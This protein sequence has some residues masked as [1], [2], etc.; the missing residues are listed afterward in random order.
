MEYLK[1]SLNSIPL[2][3]SYEGDNDLEFVSY[4]DKSEEGIVFFRENHFNA[5]WDRKINNYSALYL[6]NNQ[7]FDEFLT[8]KNIKFNTNEEYFTTS[9]IDNNS[10]LYLTMSSINNEMFYAFTEKDQKFIDQND[11]I[12]ELTIL[13]GVSATISH[14]HR[15]K[16]FYYLNFNTDNTFKFEKE[17]NNN[18]FN[19]IVDRKNSKMSLFKKL[20]LLTNT[21]I[22]SNL[23]LTTINSLTAFKENVFNINYYLETLTPKLNTSWASYN[24]KNINLYD[25]NNQRS[26]LNLKNNYLITSQYSYIS[27]NDLKCNILTLKNQKT[28]KH[29][30]HRSNYLEKNNINYPSVNHRNYI[31]LFSGSEQELGDHTIT[32]SYEFYNADYKFECDKYTIFI[33]PETLYPYEQININDLNWN[34]YGSIGG[35]SPYTSDKIFKSKIKN[36]KT[37]GEYLCSWLLKQK[38]GKSVW[39]DRYYYPDKTTYAKALASANNYKFIDSVKGLL[40]APLTSQNVY[41]VPFV[42]NTLVEEDQNTPQ[43]PKIALYGRPY[44]DKISDISIVPNTE[45]IYQRIGNKYVKQILETLNDVLIQDGL[46]LKN[47]LHIELNLEITDVDTYE[48]EFD[49]STYSM[50]EN[51]DEINKLHQFTICFWLKNDNWD[52]KMGYQIF[53]NLND[54]GFSLIDDP[55]ITPFIS[56][57]NNKTVYMYN[58]DFVYMDEISL[59]NQILANNSKIKDLY[60]TDHLDSIYTINVDINDSNVILLS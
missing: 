33:S 48:Y 30:S 57:Q 9:I 51:Y 39:L 22:L 52:N 54:R 26:R 38:D 35:D 6:T 50:L 31:G 11:R 32:L 37:G 41:D 28:H 27:G 24:N 18:L 15:N 60:R 20:N 46:T 12:F 16:N 4:L 44:F 2:S 8:L 36:T 29:Y 47:E 5:V 19:C 45:Y 23:Q 43:T 42:Y 34:Q 40:N 53:G 7:K 17:K 1:L 59:Q 14:K 55:K 13:S 58:T 21:V 56:I 10:G 25:V 49:G 3:S